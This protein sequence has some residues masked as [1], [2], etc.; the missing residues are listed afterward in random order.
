MLSAT[1]QAIS[2]KL[3]TQT[4]DLYVTLTVT[5]QTY[6][7]TI[8]LLVLL[9]VVLLLFTVLQCLYLPIRLSPMAET[10]R[11]VIKACAFLQSLTRA[12]NKTDLS[13]RLVKVL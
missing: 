3:A 6:G 5:F 11:T 8:F 13:Y 9:L 1:K 2:I 10:E 7:L 12:L 4:G